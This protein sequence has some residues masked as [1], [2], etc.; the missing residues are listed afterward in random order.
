MSFFLSSK[1]ELYHSCYLISFVTIL[2]LLMWYQNLIYYLNLF[3][4][5]IL[6]H[7]LISSHYYL[8]HLIPM[9]LVDYYNNHFNCS[10]SCWCGIVFN[11]YYYS[12]VIIIL[13]IILI[14]ITAAWF[15]NIF[16]KLYRQIFLFSISSCLYLFSIL[17]HLSYYLSFF[18]TF[19]FQL[20]CCCIYNIFIITVI[21]KFMPIWFNHCTTFHSISLLFSSILTFLQLCYKQSTLNIHTP[22][23]KLFH[24]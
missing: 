7:L 19:L 13:V 3:L 20:Y 24:L 12:S 18:H 23:I 10:F 15:D 2:S 9:S 1:I 8:F 16:C 22:F 5:H 21:N 6:F 11:C 4:F 17:F 14:I